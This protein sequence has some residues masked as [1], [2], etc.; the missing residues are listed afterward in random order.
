MIL[1]WELWDLEYN[2]AR[3]IQEVDAWSATLLLKP[4]VK[5]SLCSTTYI[6]GGYG[7]LGECFLSEG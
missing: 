7:V 3:F 6:M 2:D 4:G 1:G 5:Y